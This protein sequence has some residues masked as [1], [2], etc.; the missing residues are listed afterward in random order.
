MARPKSKKNKF[1]LTLTPAGNLQLAKY[2]DNEEREVLISDT[3]YTNIIKHL[4]R[5]NK[6]KALLFDF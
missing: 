1:E 2:D 4:I 5:I 3:D 6:D